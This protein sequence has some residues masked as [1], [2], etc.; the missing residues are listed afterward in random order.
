MAK[1]ISD[2]EDAMK[3]LEEIVNIME[4]GNVSLDESMALFEEGTGLIKRCGK[5]LDAAELKVVQL[6]KGP[7]GEP[8]EKEFVYDDGI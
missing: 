6:M 3:R 4:G 5:Q 1:K 2:F 7:D 8:M